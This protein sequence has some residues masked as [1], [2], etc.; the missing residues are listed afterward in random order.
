VFIIS[1]PVVVDLFA[2]AAFVA[3]AAAEAWCEALACAG[4]NAAGPVV[5]GLDSGCGVNGI[6]DPVDADVAAI[7]IPL[8][9][10]LL[11]DL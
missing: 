3:A 9:M 6:H 4:G 2:V 7:Q 8:K 11:N 10:F 5:G 1:I